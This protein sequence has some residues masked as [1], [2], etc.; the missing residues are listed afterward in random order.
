MDRVKD[1]VAQIEPSVAEEINAW[2]DSAAASLGQTVVSFSGT[3]MKSASGVA[4][5]MPMMILRIVLTIIST[6][7]VSV[8]FERIVRCLKRLLP[9]KVEKMVYLIKKKTVHSLKVFLCSYCLLFL[10]TFVE[11]SIGF[12][13]LRIPYPILI[14]LLVAVVDIMPVLGTGTVLLPWAV[15]AVIL[16]NIPLA[17]GMVL[18]Y[19]IITVIRNIVEPR[20]VGQQIGLHPLATLISMFLGM[21]LLGIIGLFAFPIILSL[22]L[23]FQRDGVLPLPSWMKK[24]EQARN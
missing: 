11:L 19:I 16:K 18:L 20:L 22:L 10:M 21:Q 5:S 24:A 8:D 9:K 2:A 14:G 13:T 15:I 4:A 17:I 23:Q 7:F 6:Y 12:F 1:F 3:A